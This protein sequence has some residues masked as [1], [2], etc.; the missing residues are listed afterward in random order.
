[1]PFLEVV[2][3]THIQAWREEA[4]KERE[5]EEQQQ[6]QIEWALLLYEK[7]YTW[8]YRILRV[9]QPLFPGLRE[10]GYA[11]FAYVDL[12][13]LFFALLNVFGTDNIFPDI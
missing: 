3:Q 9:T 1:M 2:L 7:F 10:T 8:L 6:Q 4:E 13:Q 5:D 11:R 12:F